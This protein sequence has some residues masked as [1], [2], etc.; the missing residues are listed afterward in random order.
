M[1]C[2]S[3]WRQKQRVQKGLQSLFFCIDVSISLWVVEM[4]VFLLVVTKQPVKG[5]LVC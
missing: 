3:N 1:C 5:Q 2:V 4:F